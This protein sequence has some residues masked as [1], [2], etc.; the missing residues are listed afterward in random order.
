[1]LRTL[2]VLSCLL[3]LVAVSADDRPNIVFIL[4][5][6][7][8][9]EVLGCYGGQSYATPALDALSEDGIRFT[10]CYSMPVCHPS[11]V[12]LLTGRYPQVIG[13]P[14]WGSFPRALEQQTF[15]SRLK[16]AGYRTAVAGKWQ[17]SLMKNDFDQPRRMGFDRWCLFGW[18]EGPRY[19]DPMIY[20]DGE[21]RDDTEG[22]YGPDL[23]VQFLIDFISRNR[24]Q[25]FL[26]YYSMALCHDVTDD[27]G[28]PV[29]YGPDGRWLS[30]PEMVADMDRQIGKLVAALDR[31]KLRENTLVVFTGDNGTAAASYLRHQDGKFVR[32]K[33]FSK[34]DGRLVQGG[35]GQLNDWGTRVPLLA[36]WPRMFRGGQVCDD[37]ID[38]SDFFPTFLELAQIDATPASQATSLPPINGISFSDRLTGSGASP[39]EWAYAEHRGKSFVR[40]R[41]HKLYSDGTFFDLVADPDERTPLDENNP[42]AEPVRDTRRMLSKSLE[43]ISSSDR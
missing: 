42:L 21:L 9:R 32:P 17:L 40:T 7:V 6:D 25:P 1:M 19:H 38:F 16:A 34:I 4:A 10:H 35:K 36:S 13:N 20:Q 27:I 12:C 8:G 26:A 28:E 11:R 37:L 23:Y 39:R 18:H 15:A 30:Y 2:S 3:T 14:S 5:D 31:L 22:K 29:P 33:V 41:T 43:S 24:E